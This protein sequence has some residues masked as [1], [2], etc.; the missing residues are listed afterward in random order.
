[1]K[2]TIYILILVVSSIAIL[3]S[4][5][6]S[7]KFN[8]NN[9]RIVYAAK[10]MINAL[11]T[12]NNGVIESTLMLVAKLKMEKSGI[13]IPQ[14]QF[15]IDSLAFS[16]SSR[17]LRYKAFLVSNIC[18]DPKWFL[19]DSS[20]QTRDAD[21]FYNAASQRLQDKMLGVNAL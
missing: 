18:D 8:S 10:N 13:D 11:R 1:M 14:I 4:Q 5:P 17:V 7:Y 19:T 15:L 3:T 9:D 12:G 21:L 2:Q 6:S 20:L 16:G